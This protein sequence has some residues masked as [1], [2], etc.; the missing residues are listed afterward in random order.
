MFH[1]LKRWELT[2]KLRRRSQ[3]V[4]I[5]VMLDKREQDDK[6]ENKD[7][8]GRRDKCPEEEPEGNTN[9]VLYVACWVL[10]I[11]KNKIKIR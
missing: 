3:A 9:P 7:A 6:D 5:Q 8:D 2:V 4:W 10:Y 1:L 11:N